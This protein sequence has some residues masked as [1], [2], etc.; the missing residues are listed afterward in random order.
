MIPRTEVPLLAAELAL[1]Y[2]TPRYRRR[3]AALRA[4]VTA[5]PPPVAAVDVARVLGAGAPSGSVHAPGV[6]LNVPAD[7]VRGA[8]VPP[9]GATPGRSP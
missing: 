9:G 5:D 7:R 6:P 2:L 4:G 8:V 1:D 3:I